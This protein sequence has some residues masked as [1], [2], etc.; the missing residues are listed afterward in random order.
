MGRGQ[1]DGGHTLQCWPASPPLAP[2]ASRRSPL[3]QFDPGA[4]GA[5]DAVEAGGTLGRFEM[6]LGSEYRGS[7]SCAA[8]IAL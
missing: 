3:R 7:R 4:I 8:A 6:G 5:V 1:V 2:Y